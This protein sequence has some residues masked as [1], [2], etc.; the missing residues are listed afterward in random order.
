ML[1]AFA[2]A[3]SSGRATDPATGY[4]VHDVKAKGERSDSCLMWGRTQNQDC[5]VPLPKA[6]SHT[7]SP[8]GRSVRGTV[9]DDS[10]P[11]LFLLTQAAAT[12]LNAM[13]RIGREPTD[14]KCIRETT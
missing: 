3:V 14:T 13:S 11:P 8:T 4:K 6:A 1:C 2:N 10:V 7:E 9:C 5:A 12:K